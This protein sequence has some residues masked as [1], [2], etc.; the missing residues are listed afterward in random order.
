[1]RMH[2]YIYIYK[3]LVLSSA[4]ED[5]VLQPRRKTASL[6]IVFATVLVFSFTFFPSGD[7]MKQSFK[8]LLFLWQL[9][10]GLK[11]DFLVFK[12]HFGARTAVL[13]PFLPSDALCAPV[14]VNYFC[15]PFV[16]GKQHLETRCW[17]QAFSLCQYRSF[18]STWYITFFFS[19][20]PFGRGLFDLL[21]ALGFFEQ[22]K[23]LVISVSSK[24]L[25]S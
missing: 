11:K 13:A 15:M 20:L 9:I 21:L 10:E 24:H 22:D 18:L 17:I 14:R 12:P 23:W 5:R 4:E 3:I 16:S 1:M 19:L 6:L 2:T 8:C 25:S 7:W